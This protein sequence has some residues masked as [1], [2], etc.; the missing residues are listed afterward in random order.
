MTRIKKILWLIAIMSIFSSA[1]IA[2]TSGDLGYTITDNKVTITYYTGCG[3]DVSIPSLISG[4]PVTSIGDSAFYKCYGLRSVFIPDSVTSIGNHAFADCYSLT[5]VMIG[6]GI[7]YMHN[8]FTSS[9]G[10]KTIF[11]YG[12]A[13]S[14]GGD[15]F[16]GST[17][18]IYYRS[19]TIGWGDTFT[20]RP[21][22][23]KDIFI[24]TFNSGAHGTLDF[25]TNPQE[26]FQEESAVAPKVTA[27]STWIFTGWDNN[28]SSVASNLTVT[29]Q[30]T[31]DTDND[32]MPDEWEQQI[33][34]ASGGALP[35]TAAVNPTADF[36]GDGHDN[37]SEYIAGM[38]PTNSA[39]LFAIQ[40]DASASTKFIMNW[41]A[42]TGRVYKVLWTG[43]L[44]NNFQPLESVSYPRN[45]YTDTVHST[46]S[47]YKFEVELE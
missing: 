29:A 21:T 8:T 14:I 18:T 36:D 27:T 31:A 13:P 22:E 45:S 35:N 41:D 44:T 1:T 23:M 12:D 46:E 26:G 11:F 47:F 16:W 33:I 3:G 24:I 28:F 32:L 37:Y 2:D 43:S 15:P 9:G 10:L 30:Y 39:S 42:V 20:G 5:S 40:A 19:G 6:N 7:T 25:T 17:P 34:D 38:S 4:F